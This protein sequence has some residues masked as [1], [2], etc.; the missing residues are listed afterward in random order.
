MKALT[1]MTKANQYERIVAI[2]IET[3]SDGALLDIG[4]YHGNYQHD[5]QYQVFP[6][7]EKFFDYLLKMKG[8][9]RV[10]AHNG[11]GFDF[12]TFN[13]WFLKN[14]KRYGI[15]DDDV[16]YLSSEALLIAMIV[17]I[18]DSSYT[19]LDTMRY[20]PATSL[21]KLSESFLGES[22]NDVPDDFISRMEDYKRKYRKQYYEYL[23]KDC[24]LL[25]RVYEE[26]RKEINEFTEIGELGLSSG[27][28]AMKSF[29]RWLG[30]DYPKT[31]IFSCPPEF[32]D[33]ADRS[34]RGGLT[35]YIGDGKHTDHKYEQVNH[36]DVVSMYPSVMRY[37]PT[38]SSP[39]VYT[40][41]LVKDYDVYRPGW[42]LCNFTQR[43]GRVPILFTLDSEYPQWQGQGIMSHFEIQ[44][45]E[46]FGTYEILDGIVYE[47]YLFPFQKYFDKLL[48]LRMEAKEK[49]QSA[50]S[51][52]LK[53][54][55]NSLYG[56]FGQ[57][58]TREVIAISSDRDWYDSMLEARLRDYDDTGITEYV[59]TDDYVIYGVESES[60][61]FSNRF[62]GAM[63]TA[64]ARLKL[65]AILNTFPAIY[66]DTDS[67]FTQARLSD[68]F[69]GS[70]PG[71]FEESEISPNTMICLGKKSYQYGDGI[72]FKGVPSKRL[73]TADIQ[74]IRYGIDKDVA[75]TSPTAWRTAMK[76]NVE[77]PNKFLPRKR[78]VRRGESLAE[79][80]LLH[81]SAKLF[82][83]KETRDFLDSILSL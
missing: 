74:D 22:K 50:K 14:R 31:K 82:D 65:G 16:T 80:G 29:R 78:R 4:C 49:K 34:L 25:Y 57:K 15:N 13:Q 43:K 10:I 54:L 37:I 75:Y 28:T 81:S 27:S 32:H 66:C 52:A 36:Y 6:N 8:D 38:P 53:I 70:Q 12:I 63:V 30:T 39:L 51:H 44:F 45:L 40:S 60:T 46:N 18:N 83:E 62:I 64:L 55:A 5:C 33:L 42:Y 11:F 19:F 72:K 58:A 67:I 7:W 3:S 68:C 47:D 79:M 1:P 56:K 71:D 23:Q 9:V 61:G 21:Q 77:N 41:G 73:T 20:F 17:R 69:I 26:F 35:L 2:D 59:V 76:N 24:E 48:A